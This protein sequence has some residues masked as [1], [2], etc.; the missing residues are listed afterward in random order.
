MTRNPMICSSLNCFFTSNLLVRWDWT[1]N[2]PATQNRGEAAPGL[3][4]SC[5][6][7]QVEQPVS[8]IRIYDRHPSR[9]EDANTCVAGW[10]K[11]KSND[12]RPVETSWREKDMTQIATG[13]SVTEAINRRCSVRSYTPEKVGAGRHQRPAGGGGT[14]TDG[15]P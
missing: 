5:S 6:G 11:V 3:P 10:I 13:M 8:T 15:H 7:F 4:L 14:I 12:Y 1:P 9:P 2:R